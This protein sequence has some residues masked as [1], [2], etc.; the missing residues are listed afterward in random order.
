KIKPYI[1]NGVLSSIDEKVKKNAILKNILRENFGTIRAEN[2]WHP[3]ELLFQL[4]SPVFIVDPKTDSYEPRHDPLDERFNPWEFN[5]ILAAQSLIFH[6]QLSTMVPYKDKNRYMRGRICS[7]PTEPEAGIDLGF[8][9]NTMDVYN[10]FGERIGAL[11]KL[12][13]ILLRLNF[14]PGV[15]VEIL[16][17]MTE[18]FKD[19]GIARR[20]RLEEL[21]HSGTSG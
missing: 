1:K 3:H 14:H 17:R 19:H 9:D 10:T 12:V 13:K 4:N 20:I 6:D 7:N 5:F 16:P 15:W 8:I 21:S 11:A 2:S 18:D